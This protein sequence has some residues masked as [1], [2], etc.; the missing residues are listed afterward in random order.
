MIA[1]PGVPA[2]ADR[3]ADDYAKDEGQY[4]LALR[5]LSEN[6]NDT[7]FGF[8]FLNYHEKMPMLMQQPGGGTPN[9]PD[10]GNPTLNFFD[11]LGYYLAYQ[12]DVKLYGFSLSSQLGATN[13]SG[14]ISYRDDLLISANTPSGYAPFDVVQ[15]LASA[16]H[17]FG[18]LSVVDMTTLMF[19]TGFNQ[20]I[21]AENLKKDDFAWGSYLSMSF[22]FFDVLPFTDMKIPFSF[23]HR[24]DNNS[25][26]PGTFNANQNSLGIGVEF[27]YDSNITFGL[28]YT[29]FLGD[30]EDDLKSDRDYLAFNIKYTF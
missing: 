7:E 2:T 12:E 28:K 21:D 9:N 16:I 23:K 4:G 24:P 19:E 20:V 22:T 25:S 11:N 15:V 26:L 5:Y 30:A 14:E 13:V 6:L 27:T 29:D 10:W 17:I 1:V 3:M 8:Y 18:P